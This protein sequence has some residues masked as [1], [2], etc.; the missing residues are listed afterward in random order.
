MERNVPTAVV[1]ARLNGRSLCS[2]GAFKCS[3]FSD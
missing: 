1:E 2:R 3:N